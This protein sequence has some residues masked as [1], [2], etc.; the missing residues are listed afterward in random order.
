MNIGIDID[1]MLSKYPKFF[2]ELGFVWRQAGHKVFIITGL[3]H[4]TALERLGKITDVYGESFYDELLDTSLYNT[5]EASLIGRVHN[6]IIV[7]KFKQR[8]CKEHDVTIM[9]DGM[10]HVY[11]LMGNASVFDVVSTTIA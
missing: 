5:N 1:G 3:E 7:G 10:T 8:M 6:E 9:F 4:N 11:R 2:T